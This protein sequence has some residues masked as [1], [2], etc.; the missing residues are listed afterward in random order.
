MH[1]RAPLVERAVPDLGDEYAV[2]VG[3]VIRDVFAGEPRRTPAMDRQAQRG[4]GCPIGTRR[5]G[6]R[7]RACRSNGCWSS[8]RMWMANDGEDLKSAKVAPLVQAH[9]TSGGSSD[10]ELN[11]QARAAKTPVPFPRVDQDHAGREAGTP[12]QQGSSTGTAVI[13]GYPLRRPPAVR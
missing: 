8:A 5:V 1:Q 9:R 4:V 10:S 2:V 7:R 13:S 6:R 11:A 12:P 3:V